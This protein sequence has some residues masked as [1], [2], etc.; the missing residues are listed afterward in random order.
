MF[1]WIK[2]IFGRR[3]SQLQEAESIPAKKEWRAELKELKAKLNN[4]FVTFSM[5]TGESMPFGRL[6]VSKHGR[7]M[8]KLEGSDAAGKDYSIVVTTGN[9]L[10]TK[11]KKVTGALHLSEAELN[12]FIS[13]GERSLD[14][15]MEIASKTGDISV[16]WQNSESQKDPMSLVFQ[17]EPIWQ[18]QLFSRI[19]PNLLALLLIRYSDIFTDLFA[20]NTSIR[21]QEIIR[22]ELYFLN[23]SGHRETVPHSKNLGFFDLDEAEKEFTSLV[24][25]IELKRGKVE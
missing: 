25:Q 13:R 8:F 5:K 10:D 4:F 21:R 6:K 12:R 1:G 23:Q 24:R 15:L 20:Q 11:G 14:D 22:D 9:F 2:K 7:R 18:Q 17:W 3:K 19:R 16:N